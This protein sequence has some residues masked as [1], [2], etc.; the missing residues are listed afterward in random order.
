ML[1]IR[2]SRPRDVEDIAAVHATCWK[3]VYAFMPQ[4]V[5][6]SRDYSFRLKQWKNWYAEKR[7]DQGEGLFVMEYGKR[8]VGFC[9]CKPNLDPD[10][11][12]AKGEYHAQ[13]VL[14]QYR[15]RGTGYQ[16]LQVLTAYL[17]SE[18]MS[19]M[20]CWAFQDNTIWQWYQ[21][22][23]FEKVIARDRIINDIAVPEYGFLHRDPEGLLYDLTMR[24]I[25]AE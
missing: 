4:E 3:D 24:L 2:V 15:A 9:M 6:K 13:Y 21:R 22:M 12:Q 17:L 14:P 7:F 18:K 11:P 5:L 20:C 1:N 23:G 16:V 8:I 19:P 25:A 10:I